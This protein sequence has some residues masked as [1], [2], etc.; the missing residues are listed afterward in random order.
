MTVTATP[1]PTGHPGY[2][3]TLP[4]EPE[5]AEIARRLVRTALTARGM[6]HLLDDGALVVT[7]LVANASD[8]S[9]SR[10][11]KVTV[12]RPTEPYVRIG[13]VDKS[14]AIPVTRLNSD[15]DD[16]RGRGLVLVDALSARWGTDLF[17]RGKRV[18]G[19]AKCEG[20]AHDPRRQALGGRPDPR[21]GPRP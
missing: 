15:G 19:D 18:W 12:T 3:E 20:P 14:R 21:R 6:E 9:G 17:H 16:L 5:S 2:S 8:H 4:C 7:E 10:F 11:I 13:V 1:R